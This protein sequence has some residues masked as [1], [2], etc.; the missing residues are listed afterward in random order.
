MQDHIIIKGA[1]EHNLKNI[2]AEIPR[3]KVVVI[4]GPSG[5][6]K[7]SLAIDTIYAEGQRRYVE[8]LSSYARQ[9]IGEMQKPEVDLIEGLSPSIAIDQKTIS[10][11]PRSTVGTITDIYNYLRV[12]YTHAGDAHCYN[13]G[14][15]I[16]TQDTEGVMQNIMS[17]PDGTRIQLL[18]T[19]VRERKGEHRQI[20]LS[21]RK[22]GFIRARVDG[23]MLDLSDNIKL[24]KSKRHTIEVVV[25]RLIVKKNF[26]RKLRNAL[27]TG[28]R[29]GDTIT[30]NLIDEERDIIFSKSLS[31]PDCGTAYP[32]MTHRLF[33]FNSKVGACPKCNGLGFITSSDEK[34]KRTC[35]S[36]KGLRLR[37]E[38][39]A[40]TIDGKNIMDLSV[41]PVT[42]LSSFIESMGLSERQRF[43]VRR[44]TKEINERLKFLADV[45]LDY[46]SLSRLTST[47][48]GGEAQRVRLAHQL[49]SSLTGVLYVLDE[50]SI[51]L[52]PSDC[53]KL[54]NTLNSIRDAGNS[55]LIVEHD[56]DTIRAADHVVD[57]GPG[58]GTL[59]GSIVAADT[60][61]GLSNHPGS[62]TGKF[63]SGKLSIP[64]PKKRRKTRK[65]IDIKGASAYNLKNID[66]RIPL[67]IFNCVTG[68]SGSGKSTLI[69][70]VLY[71]ALTED[72][73]QAPK[74][75]KYYTEVRG[76]EKID[77]V[78][79]VDQSPLG[80]SARS[81]P[82]TYTG[83]F[84]YIRD[85]FALL[86]DSKVRGYTSSRFSFNVK[87]G[88]CEDCQ[89]AGITKHEMHFLPDVFVACRT[90]KGTRFNNETLQILYKGHSISDVLEMTIADALE[91]FS[92][93]P[94]LKKRL[95]L[96]NEIGLGYIKLGQ[97]SVTL[98]G[99]EAQRIKLSRELSKKASERTLYILDEPTTGLHFVDI[100]KL[101]RVMNRLVDMGNTVLV[102]EHNPDIIK[103][104]DHIIDLGPGGGENGGRVVASG[105]PEEVS[106]IKGS[107]TGKFLKQKYFNGAKHAKV[108]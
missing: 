23:E 99:G 33:S 97:P 101:L 85:L 98:S 102:I 92:A 108:S 72:A 96:L 48:S 100:E 37:D 106:R 77:N 73:G 70:E 105:T 46:L 64:V 35:G 32:E 86:P 63:L 54:I 15:G 88:R 25:D 28:L 80:K 47:L 1:R 10:Q 76:I 95:Y 67:G 83:I 30:I 20:L 107:V 61:Q 12:L 29:H 36:C 75:G 74:D 79:Y 81:N 45:G 50:P 22:E 8:S 19:V 39:L 62:V 41:M 66:V 52:H 44:V 104:V 58:G 103:S 93:I 3:D 49:G 55:V 27:D 94:S 69:F 84:T 21:L 2:S 9:F 17:L 26:D 51:G 4:T 59:G 89:G 11:S 43:I 14:S 53:S 65:F 7:S 16:T 90:C 40:V 5:S 18:V 24:K 6:G 13:C 38:A 78:I 34:S 87:G 42:E 60:P 31:C 57:M 56:E 68:V 71:R 82:A 91:F